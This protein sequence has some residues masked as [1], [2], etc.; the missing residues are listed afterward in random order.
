MTFHFLATQDFICT[1]A[2]LIYLVVLPLV[3]YNYIHHLVQLVLVTLTVT[4]TGREAI[5]HFIIKLIGKR[6]EL[7]QF[8]HPIR[9][10]HHQ[11]KLT[12]IQI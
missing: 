11:S 4:V 5:K 1:F 7:H 9:I 10:I 2:T 12:N 8:P 3:L 6:I